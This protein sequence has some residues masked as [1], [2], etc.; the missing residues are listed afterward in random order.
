M[1]AKSEYSVA[2]VDGREADSDVRRQYARDEARE[3]FSD[4]VGAGLDGREAATDS[5]VRR[6]CARGKGFSDGVGGRELASDLM[7]W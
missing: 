2:G 3:G 6:Q 7:W 1:G 4:G 5:D